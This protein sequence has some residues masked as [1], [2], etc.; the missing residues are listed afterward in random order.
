MAGNRFEKDP[1]AVLDYSV[2]WSD[3]LNGDTIQASE[4]T[5][6]DGLT[7][8]GVPGHTDTTTTIWLAGGVLGEMYTL[9][10]QI[11]TSGGRTDERRVFVQMVEK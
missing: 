8:E 4:W 3:W 1:A 5:V 10:N 6:P 9:I 2:D 7:V 11:T